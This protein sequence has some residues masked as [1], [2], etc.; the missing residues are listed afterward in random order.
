MI[1]SMEKY[2]FL[3]VTFLFSI[4]KLFSL[5][6][7]FPFVFYFIFENLFKKIQYKK[8]ILVFLIEKLFFVL[9]LP[10]HLRGIQVV[11]DKIKVIEDDDTKK[12]TYIKMMCF[13]LLA[14]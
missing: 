1:I 12:S 14:S 9:G 11:G 3:D 8:V 4:C 10:G 7:V 13:S 2:N 5:K 6:I